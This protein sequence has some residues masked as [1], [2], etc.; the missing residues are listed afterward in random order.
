MSTTAPVF[1]TL[2]DDI[3]SHRRG[4]R[5]KVRDMYEVDD[6]L[7]MVA[8]DRISAYDFVLGSVIPDK[9]KVLT[10][11][12]AFWFERTR[13]IVPNHMVWDKTSARRERRG[14]PTSHLPAS[15]LLAKLMAPRGSAMSTTAP[16]FETLL[17]DIPSH[18]RGKVR[19]MYEVD[20]YLLMVATDRISAYDF[21]AGFRDSG[22]G[23]GAH[24]AVGVLV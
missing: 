9:G 13:D 11:L 17:D 15:R 21:C 7:L 23:E 10:Q 24:A 1:E 20:D 2:L 16:V 5:R 8:T 18:R 12:S 19:D 22:Q 4:Q 14:A 6:Y 3:P